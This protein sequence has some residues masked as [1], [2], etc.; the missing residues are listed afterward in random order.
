MNGLVAPI[1][2]QG[3]KQRIAATILDLISPSSNQHFY[4]LCCGS[5]AV[6][7]ELVNRGHDVHKITMLDKSPWGMF[8]HM[9]GNGSFDLEKFKWHIQQLPKDLS[10][11]KGHLKNLSRNP[12]A[13]DDAVYVFL[14]LQAG[15]FGG[16]AIWIADGKWKTH[17]FRSYWMPTATS[18]RKHPVNP[19]MPLPDTLLERVEIVSQRMR[20]VNGIHADINQI[21][22]NSDGVTYIDP[23]YNGTTFYGY[24]FDVVAYAKNVRNKCYVS[25]GKP[26]SDVAHLISSGRKKGGISGERKVSPNEEWL[27]EF[28]GGT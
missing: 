20:G 19:M 3:G 1:A 7:M 22:P 13:H 9:I 16:K 27:S 14:L 10:L 4:D 26:L 2:Y 8:W 17:G 18:N 28:S 11:V 21:C 24:T 15:S 12:A 25:E 6:S 23:P 5:G